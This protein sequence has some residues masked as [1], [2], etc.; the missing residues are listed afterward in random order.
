MEW[1]S[2]IGGI[3]WSKL[4]LFYG[5]DDDSLLK[6]IS[7][8]PS[9]CRTACAN[10]PNCTNFSWFTGSCELNQFKS[11]VP[12]YNFKGSTCGFVTQ[13]RS[14][15]PRP[16]ITGLQ[17]KVSLIHVVVISAPLNIIK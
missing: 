7:N 10:L 5:P 2:T 1:N 16:T 14:I 12:A 17:K 11:E 13:H 8:Q 15:T 3:K 4:C 6:T 9:D